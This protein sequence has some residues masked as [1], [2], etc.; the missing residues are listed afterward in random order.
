MKKQAAFQKRKNRSH[1]KKKIILVIIIIFTIVLLVSGINIIKTRI[2][3]VNDISKTLKIKLPLLDI[4]VKDIQ[5]LTFVDNT[6]DIIYGAEVKLHNCLIFI[7][8]IQDTESI[9]SLD[10]LPNDYMIPFFYEKIDET[11]GILL[12]GNFRDKKLDYGIG[13]FDKKECILY[14]QYVNL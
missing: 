4:K 1:S 14:F 8:T 10:S 11:Q 12:A 3:V 2:M 7:E 6:S 9:M 5:D 13:Y